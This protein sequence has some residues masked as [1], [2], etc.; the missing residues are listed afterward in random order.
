MS[1]GIGHLQV[2]GQDVEDAGHVGGALNIGVAAQSIDAAAGAPHVAQQQLQHGRGA[3]DLRAE[4]VLRPT[5][6]IDDGRD[7]LHVAV[8]ADGSEQVRGLQELVFGY[9]GDALDHLRRVTRI[10]LSSTAERRSAD[11][12]V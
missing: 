1:A 8:F 3:D 6:R 11:A 7:L 4:G 12:A 5:H 10:L 9:A 2:A